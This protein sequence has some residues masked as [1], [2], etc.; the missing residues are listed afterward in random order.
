MSWLTKK[1]PPPPAGFDQDRFFADTLW[2]QKWQLFQGVFTPGVNLVEELCDDLA[3]PKNLSGKRVLDIGAWNGCLSFECERRGAREVVALSPEDPEITG[4]QKIREVLDSRKVHYVRGT[5]YDLN[6]R[7]LGD[8]DVVLFCGV[9]Y[10][11][12]YPLLGIDNIRRVCKGDVYIETV[13]SDAQFLVREGAA[14]KRMPMVEVSPHLLSAPLWQFYRFDELNG[15]PSGWFGPNCFAV[16]QAFES[17]GFETRLLKN[18]GRATFH[19]KLKK[20]PPEFLTIGTTE[21]VHYETVASH[22]LGKEELGEA[23]GAVAVS[24]RSFSEQFLGAILTSSEYYQEN[25]NNDQAWVNSLYAC[26]LDE[27]AAPSATDLPPRKLFDDDHA[28]RE[29][30]VDHILSSTEYRR[31]LV[32]G[33]YTKYLD[34]GASRSEIG[35]WLRLLNRGATPEFIQAEFLAS[36]EYFA[37]HRNKDHLWLDQ[38]C[39]QLLENPGILDKEAYLEALEAKTATR[40]DVALAILESLEYRQRLMQAID[41][42]F[43]GQPISQQEASYWAEN[44]LPQTV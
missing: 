10:H 23:P 18:W 37:R 39:I 33:Y 26:L 13:V 19:G 20:G 22:L 43:L 16:V 35:Y 2:H 9:L 41:S 32:A 25:G 27:A 6:P 4:F 17:A 7:R 36:E 21:G 29:A 38:V 42:S 3:L 12:R 1:I 28:Y 44:L 34:R 8:F 5:V 15:D 11:L 40:A 30:V 24:G 14:V 31:R